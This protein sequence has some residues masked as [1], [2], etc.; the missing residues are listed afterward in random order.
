MAS[1]FWLQIKRNFLSRV[2]DKKTKL[3]VR[4]QAILALPSE[5]C[6]LERCL[7]VREHVVRPCII[8]S[9]RQCPNDST[10][11]IN[12]I[13]DRTN[14]L[15]MVQC[16]SLYDYY[17]PTAKY[18]TIVSIS[19][20]DPACFELNYN[21]SS[22]PKLKKKLH[23]RHYSSL[24]NLVCAIT[25]RWIDCMTQLRWSRSLYTTWSVSSVWIM[26]SVWHI[27]WCVNPT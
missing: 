20:I 5:W 7:V 11:L 27:F 26:P 10:N 6:V 24:V 15:N 12:Q 19:L 25:T 23:L 17:P 3:S 22:T 16:D 2:N 21:M 9:V 1:G 18:M 8:T 13:Y 4:D 14:P